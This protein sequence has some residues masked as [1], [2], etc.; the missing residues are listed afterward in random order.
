MLRASAEANDEPVDMKGV[1]HVNVDSGVPGD[2]EL[3]AL[4]DAAVLRDTDEMGPARARG[5]AALG[6]QATARALAVA[7]NFEMMNRLL[8]AIGVGPTKASREIGDAIGVPP[9]PRWL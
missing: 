6:E 1:G 5:I 3:G 7:G 4:A 2:A 8:D 9:P